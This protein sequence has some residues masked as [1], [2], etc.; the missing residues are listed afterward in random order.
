MRGIP[1]TYDKIH[2]RANGITGGCALP[3]GGNDKLQKANTKKSLFR[4]MATVIKAYNGTS[5]IFAKDC[6][7]VAAWVPEG[8]SIPLQGGA[9]VDFC[10]DNGGAPEQ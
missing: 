7:D 3:S 6:S 1:R 5:R 2:S 9:I 4:G 8:G 10:F